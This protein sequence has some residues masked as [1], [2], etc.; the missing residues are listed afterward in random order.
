M[1]VSCYDGFNRNDPYSGKKYEGLNQPIRPINPGGQQY[2]ENNSIMTL[3]DLDNFDNVP[4][5]HQATRTSGSLMSSSGYK[6]ESNRGWTSAFYS[7]DSGQPPPLRKML[8]NFYLNLHQT[9]PTLSYVTTVCI[10]VFI[11]WQVPEFSKEFLQHHFVCSARNVIER[12]RIHPVILCAV[13]HTGLRHLFVN[14]Y[15]FITF[16]STVKNFI[17]KKNLSLLMFV[18]GSALS[19][20]FF[21]L[22]LTPEVGSLGLS[23][24]TL[25]LFAFVARI[26]PARQFR[27]LFF[28]SIRVYAQHALLFAI[29]VSIFGILTGSKNGIAHATH[30]GGLLFGLIYYEAYVN[31]FLKRRGR[32]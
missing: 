29:F 5:L 31:G 3:G 16:G 6:T 21:H 4:P 2:Q 20:S 18:I 26:Y 19:G 15:A 24:V 32:R 30:A 23:G 11:L 12:K 10:I 27:I 7:N 22:L 9:S 8:L 1:H 25:A 17:K 28:P 14:I 13:S